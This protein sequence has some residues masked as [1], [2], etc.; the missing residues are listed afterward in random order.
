MCIQ[1][2]LLAGCSSNEGSCRMPSRYEEAEEDF[3]ALPEVRLEGMTA[4]ANR[5]VQRCYPTRPYEKLSTPSLVSA[6]AKGG[7]ATILIYDF[8][9][10]PDA[11][12]AFEIDRSGSVSRAYWLG[13]S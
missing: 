3:F 10:V 5:Y 6:R 11:L 7:E 1:A 13:M 2:M 9:E 4:A 12:V 8:Q